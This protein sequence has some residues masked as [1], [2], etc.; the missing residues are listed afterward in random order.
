MTDEKEIEEDSQG[1]KQTYEFVVQ[2]I[3][4]ELPRVKSIPQQL[5]FEDFKLIFNHYDIND[6][7]KKFRDLDNWKDIKE[8]K[9][10]ASIL[11][12]FLQNDKD[13]LPLL[14]EKQH[15][16]ID[17]PFLIDRK[18]VKAYLKKVEDLDIWKT[19]KHGV[20]Y[21]SKKHFVKEYLKWIKTFEKYPRINLL[22]AF[23]IEEA[24]ELERQYVEFWGC[25]IYLADL[26]YSSYLKKHTSMFNFLKE[27]FERMYEE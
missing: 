7:V 3:S 23:T 20:D 15:V 25:E 21:E 24:I 26:Y 6:I 11:N 8:Q 13:I 12:I 4:E 2:M 9:S 19:T 18:E 16:L 10:V 1:T 5:S 27:Y 14:W 17:E 22:K